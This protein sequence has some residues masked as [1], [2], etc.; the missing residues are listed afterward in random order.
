MQNPLLG[1]LLG[2]NNPAAANIMAMAQSAG[3]IDL[4]IQGYQAYKA[5]R[6][7]EFVSYQYEN[8]IAFRK[9]YDRHKDETFKEFLKSNAIDL[10]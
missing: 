9:F 2:Q 7:P 6:L 8:N 10:E 1:M 5:G 4:A 3:L